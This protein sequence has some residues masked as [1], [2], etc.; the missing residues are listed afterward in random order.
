M[1]LS[2]AQDVISYSEGMSAWKRKATRGRKASSG[3]AREK[4]K[5]LQRIGFTSRGTRPCTVA[6][7]VISYSAGINAWF[8]VWGKGKQ[9][10]HREGERQAVET[11]P[12]DTNVVR[13]SAGIRAS[14]KSTNRSR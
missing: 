8:S 13:Y 12:I 6:P 4:G 11:N 9:W 1:A 5:Q 3:S 2:A 14:E 7:D 10:L